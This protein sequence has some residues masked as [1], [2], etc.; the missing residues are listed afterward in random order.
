MSVSVNTILTPGDQ[1]RGWANRWEDIQGRH[2]ELL[3]PQTV[4]ASGDSIQA[5]E[6][7]L[8]WFYGLAYH[9]KDLLI[10]ETTVGQSTVEAAITNTP[11]LALLA[12]L[13]NLTKHGHLK[14]VRSGVAPVVVR[15]EGAS[16]PG[17]WRLT[18]TIQHGSATY[19]GLDFA[20]QAVDAWRVTLA[21]WSLI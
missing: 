8:T 18:L 21:A 7:E 17:G 16:C 11:T 14:S 12:D 2:D 1:D 15:R 9:L 10:R 4:A 13:A 6:R 5:A 20:S 3:K 19:D